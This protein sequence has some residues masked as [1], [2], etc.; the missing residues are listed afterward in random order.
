ME[1]PPSTP[2]RGL[3]VLRAAASP[4]GTEMVTRSPPG[5]SSSRRTASTA[6]RIICRGTRLMAH[7][8]IGWSRPGR[9]TRPTPGPPWRRTASPAAASTRAQTGSPWV[10]STSSPPSLVTQ[11]QAAPASRRGASTGTSTTHPLGVRR[12]TVSGA[13]P[14]SSSRAAAAA[15]RAAQVPVVYPQRSRFPPAVT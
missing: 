13:R 14:V 15:A 2:R 7:S 8:P 10:A 12:D 3:K 5:S 1:I 6:S 9:V 11:Q 4:P